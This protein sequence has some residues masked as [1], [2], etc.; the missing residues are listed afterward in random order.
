MHAHSRKLADQAGHYQTAALETCSRLYGGT[1]D[2]LL[3]ADLDE[4][5][6][7]TPYLTGLN[8]SR[9][10]RIDEIPDQP[11]RKLLFDNWLYNNADAVAVS[12][13]SFKNAG[14][15]KLP[16]GSSVLQMQT[17]R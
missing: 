17:L 6:V 10:I 13:V 16:D 8:R 2:W 4:Y 15:E 9:E 5:H 11:V 12:R 3:E 1:T 7:P 14:H